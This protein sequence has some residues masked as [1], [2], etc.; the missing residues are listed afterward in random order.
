MKKAYNLMIGEQTAERIKI[1]IGTAAPEGEENQMEVRGRD[2]ISGLPRKT[3][4]TSEEIREALQEPLSAIIEIVT[5]TLERAEPELAA[6]LV[7]NGIILAGGGAMLRGISTVIS[8]ATGLDCQ[9]AED[10]LTCVARGTAI[11]LDHLEEW[12]GTMEN[13]MDEA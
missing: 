3:V 4:I 6:D 1:E 7:D 13:E 8:N 12:K 11:Y 9:V 2:M 10:P 5:R